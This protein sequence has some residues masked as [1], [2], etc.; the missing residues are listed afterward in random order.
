MSQLDVHCF[1]LRQVKLAYLRLVG[2]RERLI[3]LLSIQFR[4]AESFQHRLR[5]HRVQVPAPNSLAL[6]LLKEFAD[7]IRQER[8]LNGGLQ[9][10]E[11]LRLLY[12]DGSLFKTHCHPLHSMMERETGIE[13][14]TNSLEGCDSTTELLPPCKSAVSYQPSALS[15]TSAAKAAFSNSEA[16]PTPNL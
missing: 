9:P 14:A 7:P 1:Q 16:I 12:L 15:T 3:Q 13:P 4:L 5:Q 11:F 10:A 2:K 6:E 8:L